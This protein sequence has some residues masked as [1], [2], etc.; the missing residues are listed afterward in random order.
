MILVELNK[1]RIKT[2]VLTFL[3]FL[4]ANCVVVFFITVFGKRLKTAEG[5]GGVAAQKWLFDVDVD[6]WCGTL[7]V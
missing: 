4:H 1:Y 6:R 3:E 2:F 5:G 7:C